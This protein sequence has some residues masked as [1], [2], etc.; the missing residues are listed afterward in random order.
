MSAGRRTVKLDVLQGSLGRTDVV[1]LLLEGKPVS[2]DV[3]EERPLLDEYDFQ[4]HI[5]D[6]FSRPSDFRLE[7]TREDLLHEVEAEMYQ[8]LPYHLHF[9]VHAVV[10]KQDLPPYAEG[11]EISRVVR[12]F[13]RLHKEARRTLPKAQRIRK[14]KTGGNVPPRKEGPSSRVVVRLRNGLIKVDGQIV[15]E[16]EAREALRVDA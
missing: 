14:N 8:A 6:G 3:L 13:H 1:G 9:L 5:R 2:H 11:W 7:T 12:T 16:E 10:W 15:S 4:R